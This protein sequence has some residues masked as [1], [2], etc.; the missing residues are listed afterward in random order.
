MSV[1]DLFPNCK[2][3][4]LFYQKAFNFHTFFPRIIL[5]K[6]VFIDTIYINVAFGFEG[7]KV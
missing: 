1:V 2:F 4:F 7:K 3:S 5:T 6:K